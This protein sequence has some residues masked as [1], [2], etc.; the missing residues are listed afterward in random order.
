[1]DAGTTPTGLDLLVDGTVRGSVGAAG[2][3][4]SPAYAT[5]VLLTGSVGGSVNVQLTTGAATVTNRGAIGRS[6]T[7]N[8]SDRVSAAV[9]L[10]GPIGGSALVNLGGSATTSSRLTLATSLRGS[11]YVFSRSGQVDVTIGRD[12]GDGSLLPV[13]IGDNLLVNLGGGTNHFIFNGTVGGRGNGTF[14]Y[15]GG[16]GSDDVE[17]LGVVARNVRIFTGGGD[18]RVAMTGTV[19]GY[20]AVID[21]GGPGRKTWVP[22]VVVQ[23][24]LV[25]VNYP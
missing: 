4:T 23:L 21:F 12:P 15:Q 24:A 3:A 17:V 10:Q 6:F 2:G 9:D 1:V 16:R 13:T 18:D 11:A 8:A 14:I 20:Q 7:L 25:L 19:R 22:P 5:S